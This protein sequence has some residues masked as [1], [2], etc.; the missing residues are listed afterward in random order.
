MN[1]EPFS[2]IFTKNV[3][4]YLKCIYAHTQQLVMRLHDTVSKRWDHILN[5]TQTLYTLRPLTM[6]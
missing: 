3:S 4:R 1:N 6:E 5:L 2:A